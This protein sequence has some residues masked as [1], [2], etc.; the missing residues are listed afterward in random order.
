MPPKADTKP[1]VKD[2]AGKAGGCQP[3]EVYHS[4]NHLLITQFH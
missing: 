3:Y 1:E 4:P 2:T